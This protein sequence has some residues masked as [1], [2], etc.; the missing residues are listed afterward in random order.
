M[1]LAL[2][3]AHRGRFGAIPTRSRRSLRPAEGCSA[4]ALAAIVHTTNPLDNNLK[5]KPNS[6]V[7]G[8]K[9][10]AT[11]DTL[12]VGGSSSFP[13]I[14]CVRVGV[15]EQETL[16]TRKGRKQKALKSTRLL[17]SLVNFTVGQT[18]RSWLGAGVNSLGAGV[19]AYKR[20]PA[21]PRCETSRGS[22]VELTVPFL[23]P[24]PP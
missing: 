9:A 24:W 3:V 18:D 23:V 22:L 15:K 17:L 14:T 12:L 13:V 6:S 1:P 4:L 21:R 5:A 2:P 19:I 8:F 20:A 16:S 7:E 10:G 11:K